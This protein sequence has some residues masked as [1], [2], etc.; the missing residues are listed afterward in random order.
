MNGD[1]GLFYNQLLPTGHEG[2][3]AASN[4]QGDLQC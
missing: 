3:L 2:R 4:A 1:N